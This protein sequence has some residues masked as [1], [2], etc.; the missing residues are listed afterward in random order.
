M[1][2]IADPRERTTAATD[3]L[4]ALMAARYAWQLRQLRS[5]APLK[6]ALWAASFAG[7]GVAGSLGA[8]VHGLQLSERSR[9]ALWRPLNLCLG[10]VVA[11]F[12]A[13]AVYDAWGPKAARR[14]LPA[15]ILGALGFYAASQR[16]SR[17]FLVFIVYEAVVMLFA[18]A[19]YVRLAR[20]GRLEGA[21]LMAAGILLS[22]IAA[23]I[24]A[25][26]L[27]LEVAGIPFDHNGLFH[28]VQMAG[29]P[30]IAA[31]LRADLAAHPAA[32]LGPTSA[33]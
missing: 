25:S 17:G 8:V 30:L 32:D 22:I 1:H 24:Q 9:A 33:G 5:A 13:G 23:A 21:N 11:L 12:A 14:A 26:P 15:L 19:A 28:L 29:L 10:V 20:G 31:G 4:I 3:A 7:L 6:A 18:L 2:L 16:L 27:D